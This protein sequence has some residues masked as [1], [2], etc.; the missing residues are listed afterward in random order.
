MTDKGVRIDDGP[1]RT[2]YLFGLRLDEATNG[3]A[4]LV[5][6]AFAAVA[7]LILWIAGPTAALALDEDG[8][9]I[10]WGEMLAYVAAILTTLTVLF[11]GTWLAMRLGSQL[12]WPLLALA[13]GAMVMWLAQGAEHFPPVSALSSDYWMLAPFLFVFA[14]PFGLALHPDLPF[15]SFLIAAVIAFFFVLPDVVG[16]YTLDLGTQRLTTYGA[17]R[18]YGVIEAEAEHVLAFRA[19]GKPVTWYLLCLAAVWGGLLVA[20]V[21][22]LL[23]GR[24]AGV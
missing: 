4:A 24:R 9:A 13:V 11:G 2:T 5:T 8:R 1:E 19:S 17:M 22:G 6:A 12:Q 7:F 14:L 21:V 23:R 20:P 3:R 16:Y 10:K 18:E 15:R